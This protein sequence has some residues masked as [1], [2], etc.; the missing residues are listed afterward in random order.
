V[1]GALVL[2][3]D[4]EPSIRETIGFILE[5][6][7]FQVATAEDGEQGLEAVRRLR[8]PVVLLDAMMPKRDGYDVCHTIKSDPELAGVHVIMLTAMGQK[9]DRE[10]GLAAGADYFVTKPFDEAELL[11][12]LR[13]LTAPEQ[14]K[15]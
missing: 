6:E 3:V 7:G 5:M 14:G 9:R 11:S 15:Q 10:R 2:I 13:R 1:S 4:D 8:P 12:L